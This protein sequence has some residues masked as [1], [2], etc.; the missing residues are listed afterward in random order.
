MG[1]VT[2][3][4]RG[5]VLAGVAAF[6]LASGCKY[7]EPAQPEAPSAP[8]IFPNYTSPDSTLESMAKGIQ[9][10]GRTN[11]QSVYVGALSDSFQAFFDPL[12]VERMGQQ[13]VVPPDR[14]LKPDEDVFYGRFIQL[15]TVPATAQYVMRW[16]KDQTQGEDVFESTTAVLHREYH[17]YAILNDA[18]EAVIARGFATLYFV[19]ESASHWALVRWQDREASDAQ[20]DKGEICFGQR[21][22]EH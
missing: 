5:L 12:T 14:W 2:G 9:D 15:R 21:R 13:G 1:H 4:Y 11:G 3:T 8:S 16:A 17:V 6:T 20:I 7:F 18:D 19:S 22:L 10:K